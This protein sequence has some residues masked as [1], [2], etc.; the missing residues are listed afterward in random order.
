MNNYQKRKMK[1]NKILLIIGILLFI[2]SMSLVILAVWY[3]PLTLE[4]L[5]TGLL[6]LIPM[7][8]TILLYEVK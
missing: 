3:K 6:L 8:V 1:L 2:I 5:V 4:L 7:M